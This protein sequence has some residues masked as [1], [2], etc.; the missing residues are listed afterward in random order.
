MT[1]VDAVKT[2]YSKYA[3]FEGCASR[4]EYWWYMLF[5]IL[6]MIGCA[7]VSDVLYAIFALAN[8]LPSIAAAT[9]R[10]HDTDRSGWLQLIAFIPLIGWIFVLVWYTQDSKSPNRFCSPAEIVV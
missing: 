6:V 1:F 4:S 5:S 3:D 10:L 2:C 8:L 9:R 7:V